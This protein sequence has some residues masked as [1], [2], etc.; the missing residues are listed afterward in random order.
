MWLVTSSQFWHLWVWQNPPIVYLFPR[1]PLFA[2]Q[3]HLV[4]PA[5]A[6]GQQ[7]FNLS[8]DERGSICKIY[9]SHMNNNT[10]VLSVINISII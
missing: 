1:V 4:L 6:I 10:K 7:L 8:E 2:W 9:C 3:F 5:F